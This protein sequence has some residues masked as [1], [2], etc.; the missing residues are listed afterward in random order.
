[1]GIFKKYFPTEDLANQYARQPMNIANRVYANRMGNGPEESGDGWLY[2]GRGPIQ[3]TGKSN[4]M[5][6]A[7]EMFEDWENLFQ[8]PDWVNADREFALMSAIWF[9]NKNKLNREADA[10]DIKTMTRKIN[11]GF[12]GLEDR[13]KHYN[14]AIHLLHG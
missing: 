3:L 6:F 9:W 12:I 13:I 11:G 4:Y 7:K 10:G 8:N 2:R 5:A 14:E 1:M